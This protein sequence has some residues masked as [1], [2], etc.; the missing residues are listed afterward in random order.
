MR[1]RSLVSVVVLAGGLLWGLMLELAAP[2]IGPAA[3]DSHSVIVVM[4]SPAGG[5]NQDSAALQLLDQFG[6]QGLIDLR[7]VEVEGPAPGSSV[8]VGRV[9][10]TANMTEVLSPLTQSSHVLREELDAPRRLL[11]VDP[12]NGPLDA[13]FVYQSYYFDIGV[14]AMWARGFTGISTTQPITVAVI[15][16]GVD[17]D[18]P[19]ISANLVPGF[20]VV[21][22]NTLP[23]DQSPDSHGSMVAGIIAAEINNDVVNHVARGVAGL[24]GGDAM[25]GTPGLRLMPVRVSWDES[26]YCAQSAQAIDYAR[27]HGARVINLSYGGAL[28]GT[29]EYEAIQR[30]YAAGIA[31]VAGAGNDNSAAPFYPAAYGAGVNDRLVIAVAGVYASGLKADASN[32]GAWVDISAPF[33]NIRSLTRD[34]G[35]ASGSGTSFSA[36]F[37]SGLIGVL[38]SNFG[39]SRDRAVSVVLASADNVDGANPSQYQ[40]LLG[41]GRINADRASSMVHA[42]FLPLAAR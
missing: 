9:A 20:D 17:L 1:A 41:A 39:W 27:L 37:V 15:D 6:P 18:H 31:L 12:V 21:L 23:Q 34:G 5:M 29:L 35:Y 36:P 3:T 24:G 2:P 13:E 11:Y 7:P 30:A 10:S 14:V 42:V 4:R 38:M 16:T 8:Y 25:S 33:R 28:S 26:D 19:D 40:G 32:Y 22:S